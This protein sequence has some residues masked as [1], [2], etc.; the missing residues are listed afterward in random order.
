MH[1]TETGSQL[2]VQTRL[3]SVIFILIF[4]LCAV[5]SGL[6]FFWFSG[7][8]TTLECSRLEA[9]EVNCTVKEVCAGPG[10][11]AGRD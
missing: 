11:L 7:R 4:G 8:S 9:R 5:L 6:T 10:G 1:V 2:I 3:R